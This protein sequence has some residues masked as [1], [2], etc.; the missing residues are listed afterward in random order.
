MRRALPLL[1]LAAAL[2]PTV[3]FAH[4]GIGDTAGFLH[5]FEHPIG[6]LDHILAMVAVG[7]FAYVLSGRALWLVPAAF[8]G[9]MVVGFALGVAQVDVPFVEL[10]IALSSVVIGGAAALG[11]PMPVGAAMA[12]VGV[13][14]VFHGHAHGA[15]MPETAGGLTYAAG[16]IAATALLHAA[17][18]ALAFGAASL[19][20]RYGR[21]VAR[22]AG[23]VFALGGV[24]VLAGWL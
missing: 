23:A 14:A 9:M 11:R 4:T 19:I 12:L 13:F 15:E 6:G 7:V 2:L 20:G 8:V 24:G 5:G 3:A 17:G 10:G 22:A 21:T 16:F 18:I 1:A